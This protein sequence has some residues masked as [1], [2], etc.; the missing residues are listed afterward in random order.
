MTNSSLGSVIAEGTSDSMH[1]PT[2]FQSVLQFDL[3]IQTQEQEMKE[4]ASGEH[5]IGILLDT[6]LSDEYAH[7]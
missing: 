2:W 5:H 6:K 3:L 4:A 1:R 7:V